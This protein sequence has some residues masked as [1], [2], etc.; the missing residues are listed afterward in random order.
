[1][2]RFFG[3]KSESAARTSVGLLALAFTKLL[4]PIKLPIA[5]AITLWVTRM[6]AA[7]RRRDSDSNRLLNGGSMDVAD[8]EAYTDE[9]LQGSTRAIGSHS[10]GRE[11]DRLLVPLP[12]DTLTDA[13]L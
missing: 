8:F 13:A 5:G 7:L 12:A 3:I 2:L 4:V 1:M 10:L 11:Q 9:D 6:R